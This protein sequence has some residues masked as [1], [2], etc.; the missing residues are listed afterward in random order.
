MNIGDTVELIV[1]VYTKDYLAY[2]SDNVSFTKNMRGIILEIF[3]GDIERFNIYTIEFKV[4]GYKM[5][6][7]FHK[8]CFRRY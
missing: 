6:G 8:S 2:H 5:I 7:Q 1:D 3:Y 4:K